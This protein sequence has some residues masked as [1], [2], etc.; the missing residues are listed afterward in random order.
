MSDEVYVRIRAEFDPADWPG[1]VQIPVVETLALIPAEEL[2]L[3]KT[4]IRSNYARGFAFSSEI[5]DNMNL[6]IVS[7]EHHP[8]KVE[9]LYNF[10]GEK[11]VIGDD[12]IEPLYDELE[13]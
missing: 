9:A 6:R 8:A 2:P 5:Y 11:L 13:Q 12:L 1:K 7:E 3:L 10:I 4:Y